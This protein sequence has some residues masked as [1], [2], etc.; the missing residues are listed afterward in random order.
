MTSTGAGGRRRNEKTWA[1]TWSVA[2]C[3][4]AAVGIN[5]NTDWKCVLC[6]CQAWLCSGHIDKGFDWSVHTHTCVITLNPS[7]HRLQN[8]H[9]LEIERKNGR[10]SEKNKKTP[11]LF[12]WISWVVSIFKCYMCVQASSLSYASPACCSHVLFKVGERLLC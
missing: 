12:L 11:K 9:R 2:L 1:G 6:T 4:Q 5:Q 3:P 10:F 7:E 8:T